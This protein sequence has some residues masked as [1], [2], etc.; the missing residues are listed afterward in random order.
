MPSCSGHWEEVQ[1]CLNKGESSVDRPDIVCR[2]FHWKLKDL[3]ELMTVNHWAGKV[4]SWMY[5]V[6][7]QKRGLPHAHMLF[8]LAE[9]DAL[10]TPEQIDLLVSAEIPSKEDNKV[11]YNLVNQFMVHGPCVSFNTNS[12]CLDDSKKNCEKKYPMKYQEHTTCSETGFITYRRRSVKQGGRTM[13]IKVTG[14]EVAVTID[15]KV[16]FCYCCTLYTN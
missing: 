16:G 8:I 11:V 1:R 3:L 9:K 2:V 6:E 10:K 5:C 13:E 14:Q 15:N 7:F 12:P 4:I